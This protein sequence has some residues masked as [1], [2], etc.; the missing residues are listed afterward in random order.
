MQISDLSSRDI[1]TANSVSRFFSCENSVPP[2]PTIPLFCDFIHNSLPLQC[3]KHLSLRTVLN[4]TA[5]G[6]LPTKMPDDIPF[7]YDGRQN[8]LI[9]LEGL[10]QKAQFEYLQ[11]KLPA[12]QRCQLDLA[13]PRSSFGDA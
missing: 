1:R 4:R 7:T 11:S 3:C 5:S 6:K 12:S 8:Y 2:I 13:T 9:C 10:P